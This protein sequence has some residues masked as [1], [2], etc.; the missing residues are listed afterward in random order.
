MQLKFPLLALALGALA[1][2]MTGFAADHI[3]SPA[4]VAEPSAD[5]SDLYAWMNSD[6]SKLNLILD[7]SPFASAGSRFSDAVQYVFHVNS[8]AGY[9]MPQRET[10]IVCEFD[11][12]NEVA[13][14]VGNSDYLQGDASATA[15]ISSTSG[16]VRAFAGLRDDPF[17]MEFTGFTTAVSTVKGAAGGLSFDAE[18]C[19]NVDAATSGVLVGQLQAGTNG[20]AA[21]NTFAGSNVLSLVIQVDKDLVD[22]NG[23]VL[24]VWAS[25]NR[26]N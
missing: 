11:A 17:F 4:A 2:P 1:I 16:K 9:G 13:C 21:S 10:L 23:P 26:A 20:A 22:G 7:V 5:I 25:T 24:A 15:G 3:D 8:S 18:G 19:P 12:A 14:W 6:A